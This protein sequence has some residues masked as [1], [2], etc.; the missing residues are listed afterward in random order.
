MKRFLSL[1]LVLVIMFTAITVYTV[2][3]EYGDENNS[4][5]TVS[6]MISEN[7]NEASDNGAAD[8][9][10]MYVIIETALVSFI[11]MNMLLVLSKTTVKKKK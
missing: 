2:P 8:E 5:H 7:K 1:I 6:E 4:G 11:L 9:N 10:R 3:P